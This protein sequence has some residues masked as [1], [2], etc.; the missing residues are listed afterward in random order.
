[1]KKKHYVASAYT[2][3]KFNNPTSWAVWNNETKSWT[4]HMPSE[5]KRDVEEVAKA[6]NESDLW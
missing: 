5:R 6:L 2:H 3:G 4:P 1:M